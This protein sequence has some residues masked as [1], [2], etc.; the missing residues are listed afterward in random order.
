[1]LNMAETS[2]GIG[3]ATWREVLTE[4]WIE[5]WSWQSGATLHECAGDLLPRPLL[6]RGNIH[7]CVPRR[8]LC[9]RNLEN[10]LPHMRMVFQLA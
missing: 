9:A 5:T 8:A 6:P 3:L 7:T 1:M 2:A 4:A 10:R